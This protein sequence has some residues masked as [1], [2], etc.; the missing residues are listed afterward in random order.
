VGKRHQFQ[1]RPDT[2]SRDK[3]RCGAKLHRKPKWCKRWPVPGKN[4]CRLHGGLST[5]ART[6]DGKAKALMA[7]REGRQ[8]W[9][10]ETRAKKAAG[11]IAR[12]PCGR[13]SGAA[14]L[15]AKM[16]QREWIAEIQELRAE[17]ARRSPAAPPTRRGR[18]SKTDLAARAA[19]RAVPARPSAT[20]ERLLQIIEEAERQLGPIR[21]SG[22]PAGSRLRMR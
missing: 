18:P 20:F 17:D 10:E 9:L 7:M 19:L 12:F 13:K 11:L 3:Q 5:G 2:G 15:T 8:R 16:R 4:R 1:G 22:L 21:K 14:W 6:P